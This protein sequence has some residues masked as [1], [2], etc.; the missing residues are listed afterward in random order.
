[1]RIYAVISRVHAC[2]PNHASLCPAGLPIGGALPRQ[3]SLSGDG[4]ASLASGSAWPGIPQR[5]G[6]RLPYQQALS[7]ASVGKP[8]PTMGII[9]GTRKGCSYGIARTAGRPAFG[10]PQASPAPPADVDTVDRADLAAL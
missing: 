5:L 2:A 1:M 10:G 4:A 8:Y 9:A 7:Y 6:G 3:A